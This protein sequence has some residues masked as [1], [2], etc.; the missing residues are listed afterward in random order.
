VVVSAPNAELKLLPGMTASI[1]FEVD[2]RT[3]VLK[4]P[5]S[6]LR[7]FPQP[8]HVREQDKALLEGQQTDQSN[9]NEVTDTGLSAK[10]RATARN[11]RSQRHVWVQ[12]RYKLRAVEVQTG[13]SDSQFTELVSGALKKGDKLVIG[14]QPKLTTWAQ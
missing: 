14:I 8:Q 11:K 1:S 6:A 4:I 12:E 9:T 3:V 5:N 13:L 7:F 10:D 2:R